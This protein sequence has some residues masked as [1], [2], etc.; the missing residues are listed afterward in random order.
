MTESLMGSA[1]VQTEDRP[2]RINPVKRKG[3]SNPVRNDEGA[4]Q[5]GSCQY[6]GQP[7]KFW[8]N[9]RVCDRCLTIPQN[10]VTQL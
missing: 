2:G 8:F 7:L 5:G 6:C 1:V 3:Y 10:A 9:Y 4:H